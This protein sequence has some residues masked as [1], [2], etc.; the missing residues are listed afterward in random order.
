VSKVFTAAAAIHLA[1]QRGRQILERPISEL[2]VGTP[3]RNI[4]HPVSLENLLTH[5]GG[6]DDLTIGV[7]TRTPQEIIPL[8]PYLAGQLPP[9]VRTPGTVASYSNHGFALIGYVV[10]SVTGVRFDLYADSLLF[11]PIGM[12]RTSFAQPLPDSLEA[13]RALS[14]RYANGEQQAIPR[15]YF[16]DMPASAAFTTGADMSRWMRFLLDEHADRRSAQVPLTRDDVRLLEA[17]HFANDPALPGL[18]FGMAE[19][20]QGPIRVLEQGGDWE[21]YSS[22]LLLAPSA[23]IGLFAAFNSEAGNEVPQQLWSALWDSWSAESL[24]PSAVLTAPTASHLADHPVA[25]ARYTGTYRLNRYS[26]GTIARLGVLTG[27]VPEVRVSV[28]REGL[29]WNGVPLVLVD[30]LHFRR[31]SDGRL[32]AFRFADSRG[33]AS[34]VFTAADPYDGYERVPWWDESAVQL[35][36]VSIMVV[37]ILGALLF[38]VRALRRRDARQRALPALGLFATLDGLALLYAVTLGAVLALAD[39]WSFQ[40]GIPF[41]VRTVLA[42]PWVMIALAIQAIVSYR[43]HSHALRGV[44][45]GSMRIGL[46]VL[47]IVFL[48]HWHLILGV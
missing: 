43:R 42:I 45:R 23:R 31:T 47:F 39:P 22:D 10:Q 14:Y 36:A 11:R 3:L 16:N 38:D 27:D 40:Y 41:Y 29:A 9:Q 26:R 4:R 5:S 46:Q 1:G 24:D 30:S 28:A 32:V 34:H 13:H 12:L 15:I 20:Q 21:D 6:F 44:V 35:A 37:L 2:L 19:R 17:H 7:S 25:L 18:A 8:G 33:A 48:V